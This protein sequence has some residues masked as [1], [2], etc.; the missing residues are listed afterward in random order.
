[1]VLRKLETF[2]NDINFTSDVRPNTV[3]SRCQNNKTSVWLT[4]GRLVIYTPG[5]RYKNNLTKN[6]NRISFNFTFSCV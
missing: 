1:M 4:K 2:Y 5:H 3:L 6:N